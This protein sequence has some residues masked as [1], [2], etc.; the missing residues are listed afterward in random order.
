MSEL[1]LP[2]AYNKRSERLV[3]AENA[4]KLEKANYVCPNC[5]NKV[6]LRISRK[7]P[8]ENGYKRPHFAHIGHSD[9]YCS[10]SILHKFFKDAVVD[11]INEK[12]TRKKDII[13]KYRCDI[14]DNEH[15][16][17][18]VNDAVRIVAEYDLGVCRP[19]IALLNKDN[20][21]VAV[22]EIIVMHTPSIDTLKYYREHNILCL[23][24]KLSTFEDCD[25]IEVKL[26]HPTSV[27][28]YNCNAPLCETCCKPLHNAY[29]LKFDLFLPKINTSC[30]RCSNATIGMLVDAKD[31]IIR[32]YDELPDDAKRIIINKAP[33]RFHQ[34]TN[35]HKACNAGIK[36]FYEEGKLPLRTSPNKIELGYMCLHCN[37]IYEE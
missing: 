30:Y 24:I 9:N 17:N 13:F 10:E 37:K 29:L 22:V 14:C 25:N 12:I 4:T 34:C 7:T 27:N 11:F 21:V 2:F 36:R 20:E 5:G 1:L 35:E 33:F 6:T 32:F 23:Q 19:D 26:T 15:S 8:Y 18:L 28:N 16:G 3:R 31:N